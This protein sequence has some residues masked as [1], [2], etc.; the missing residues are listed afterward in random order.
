MIF[1]GL[2][3]QLFP[4]RQPRLLY[5][6]SS[7][8]II[9]RIRTY[10]ITVPPVRFLL[11]TIRHCPQNPYRFSTNHS[12]VAILMSSRWSLPTIA[13]TVFWYLY[14]DCH[15]CFRQIGHPHDISQ[16]NFDR[17]SVGH[18]AHYSPTVNIS[19]IRAHQLFQFRL[20][21]PACI[22]SSHEITILF[23]P[24]HAVESS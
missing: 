11:H 18:V 4:R 15:N 24:P 23:Y 10:L 19:P 22:R 2:F 8:V 12:K 7:S 21:R 5:L 9:K 14:L 16:Y 13:Q 17:N 1:S 3:H 6:E 20:T